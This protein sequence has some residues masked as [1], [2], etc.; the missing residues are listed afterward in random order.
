MAEESQRACSGP[1]ESDSPV[2][3]H[4]PEKD[5]NI[6]TPGRDICVEVPEEP[7]VLTP[8]VARA[9]LKLLTDVHRRRH[10]SPYA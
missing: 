9:L 10:G 4:G 7:P 5:L 8:N 6:P 3:A 2:Y 1:P